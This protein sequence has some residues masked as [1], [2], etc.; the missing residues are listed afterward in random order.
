MKVYVLVAEDKDG[1]PTFS[2]STQFGRTVRAYTNRAQAKAYAKR[3][4]CVA[5]ELNV[6]DGLVVM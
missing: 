2:M 4:G 6:E 5:I 3:F 1:E